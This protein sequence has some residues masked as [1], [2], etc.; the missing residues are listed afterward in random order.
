MSLII[1]PE[2]HRA[3]KVATA[4]EGKEMSEVLIEFIK[5]YVQDHS[6]KAQPSTKK[7][8]RA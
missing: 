7:A 2:L 1:A 4:Y 8:G 6:P 5:Q 3:F